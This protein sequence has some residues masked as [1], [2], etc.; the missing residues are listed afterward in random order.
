MKHKQQIGGGH[1]YGEP[2]TRD[3]HEWKQIGSGRDGY[4]V[5]ECVKCNVVRD[6]KPGE[7]PRYR[8]RLADGQWTARSAVAPP[9]EGVPV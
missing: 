9:C 2:N 3:E 1:T 8:Q 5:E 7:I 4:A 6:G